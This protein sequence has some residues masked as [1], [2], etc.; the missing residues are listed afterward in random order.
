LDRELINLSPATRRPPLKWKGRGQPHGNGERG[1][2]RADGPNQTTL[3]AKFGHSRGWPEKGQRGCAGFAKKNFR[4][5]AKRDP[6]RTLT[7]KKCFA[8]FCFFSLPI[9]AKLIERIFALFRFQKFLVLL[10]FLFVFTY[11]SFSFRFRC[12]KSEKNTFSHRS[13]KILT[14]VSLHFASKRKLW[15]FF[16]SVS[17][18]FTSKQK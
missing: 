13:E 3:P 12:E 9:K 7:R 14:P 16:A 5:K 10:L 1:R 17:L 18:H 4:F 6:F 11:F 2:G 8:S 15:Q